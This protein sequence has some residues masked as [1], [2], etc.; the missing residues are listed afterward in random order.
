MKW[1]EWIWWILVPVL[2]TVSLVILVAA[3]GPVCGPIQI[4]ESYL[5]N[6]E[7]VEWDGLN[8]DNN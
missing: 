3:Q 2:I 7:S 1:K 8:S 6:V 4:P 5:R